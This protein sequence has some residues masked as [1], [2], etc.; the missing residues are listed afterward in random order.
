MGVSSSDFWGYPHKR[1]NEIIP[2]YT[3]KEAFDIF[4]AYKILIG[5]NDSFLPT[6]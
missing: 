2:G 3:T 6:Y 1:R 4:A 5:R